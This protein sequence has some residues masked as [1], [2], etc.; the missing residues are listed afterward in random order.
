MGHFF[1]RSALEIVCVCVC[2]RERERGEREREERESVCVYVW[3]RKCVCVWVREKECVC[4]CVRERESKRESSTY[5]VP[6]RVGRPAISANWA[7]DTYC[8]MMAKI[9]NKDTK[10]T[11]L[12]NFNNA[13]PSFF[14]EAS[15]RISSQQ[16]FIAYT[17]RVNP[18]SYSG[19]RLYSCS[20][21]V[22][23]KKS[24]WEHEPSFLIALEVV[25]PLEQ[26]AP[27]LFGTHFPVWHVLPPPG[28]MDTQLGN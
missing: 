2:V 12:I 9:R 22:V 17:L 19:E 21:P 10:R 24:V 11:C 3:D 1:L 27:E 26:P 16:F 8:A 5:N 6:L 7:G 14:T 15:S 28:Y 25:C 4:V 13:V 18:A 23:G 20:L